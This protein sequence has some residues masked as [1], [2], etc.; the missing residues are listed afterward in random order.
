MIELKN[1]YYSYSQ[2]EESSDWALKNINLQIS[3][4]EFLVVLG[5]NGSGKSTLAK[6]LNGMLLPS[7]GECFVD[8]MDTRDESLTFSIREKVGMVFQNP[9][10]QIVAAIVEE[11]VAFGPE[12]L[13]LLSEEIRQRVEWALDKV[14]MT[15]YAKQGPHL[16]SGGQ[17]QRVAIAGALALRSSYIVFDEST[18]MLDPVGRK[19]V[20]DIMEELKLELGISVI[21]ITHHMEEALLADRVIIMDKGTIVADT[22]P[23]SIFLEEDIFIQAGLEVPNIILLQSILRKK[24]LV[25]ESYLKIDELVD[26]LWRLKS[27]N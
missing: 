14:K 23:K 9:D 6:H 15:D 26:E 17:K 19:E 16:L 12:N 13:G 3:S 24:G 7:L 5:G 11:D 4:G 1:V 10:N 25:L 20:L 21:L 22:S 2:G 27:Q 8:G 18:A